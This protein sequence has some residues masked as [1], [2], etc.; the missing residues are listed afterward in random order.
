MMLKKLDAFAAHTSDAS[1]EDYC[2][3]SQFTADIITSAR[4]AW[5]KVFKAT[6]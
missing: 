4:S 3:T 6:T 1:V 2:I 5:K